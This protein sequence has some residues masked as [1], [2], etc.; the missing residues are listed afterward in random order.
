MPLDNETMTGVWEVRQSVVR[1]R[2]NAGQLWIDRGPKTR[3]RRIGQ[4]G[5]GD[6]G[7]WMSGSVRGWRTGG[8]VDCGKRQAAQSCT[9]T[10]CVALNGSHFALR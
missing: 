2:L 7:S 3:T 9:A 6:R 10:L 8:V 1:E 4:L 5:G